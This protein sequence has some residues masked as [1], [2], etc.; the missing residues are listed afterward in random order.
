[1]NRSTNNAPDSLSTSYLIGSAFI[2]ISI[3]T[4]KSSGKLRPAGTRSRLMAVPRQRMVSGDRTAR[5]GIA[6]RDARS[7]ALDVRACLLGQLG[8]TQRGFAKMHGGLG[9]LIG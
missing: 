4:L 7:A 2:G 6:A 1:M 3:T 8:K 5:G 9:T